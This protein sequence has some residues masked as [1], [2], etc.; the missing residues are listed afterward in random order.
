MGLLFERYSTYSRHTHWSQWMYKQHFLST[1]IARVLIR[2]SKSRIIWWW[3]FQMLQFKLIFLIIIHWILPMRN[4]ARTNNTYSQEK[5]RITLA[6]VG[7]KKRKHS[8]APDKKHCPSWSPTNSISQHKNLF[9]INFL[10][11]SR[12]PVNVCSCVHAEK[13][14]NPTHSVK[15]GK[16][17]NQT[18]SS[19]Q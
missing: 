17:S 7:K 10:Q 12:Q 1:E 16:S 14:G 5:S 11:R 3:P 18:S 13:V 2:S 19:I 4:R 8:K 15:K 9:Q 6:E